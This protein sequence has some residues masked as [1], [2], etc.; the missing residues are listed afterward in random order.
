MVTT[1]ARRAAGR[2]AGRRRPM[3]IKLVLICYYLE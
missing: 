2:H 3:A 1:A